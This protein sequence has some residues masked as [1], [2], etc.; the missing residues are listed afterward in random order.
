MR[1]FVKNL[2]QSEKIIAGVCWSMLLLFLNFGIAR[3][4]FTLLLSAYTLA[5]LLYVFIM[6]RV[7]GQDVS[8]FVLIS[9]LVRACVVFST[10]K[11]SDDIYRFL[12]DGNLFTHGINP[13]LYTPREV[14]A[15]QN[16]GDIFPIL[17]S[18]INSPDYFSVY[19][20]VLQFLFATVARIFPQSVTAQVF[21]FKF[22][23]F[24]FDCSVLTISYQ[25]SVISY[26]QINKKQSFYSEF[27]KVFK[28]SK[29][30]RDISTLN[31][32]LPTFN[33]QPSTQILWYALNPLVVTELCGNAHA[34]GIMIFFL[35]AA[36]YFFNRNEKYFFLSAL[37]MSLSIA[38]KLL[39]LMLLPFLMRYL[40]LKIFIKYIAV[41]FGLSAIYFLPFYSTVLVTHFRNSLGLYFSKFE[42]NASLFYVLRAWDFWW[43]GYDNIAQITPQLT[44]ATILFIT[45]LLRR[46]FKNA[47]STTWSSD[48]WEYILAALCF[49]FICATT[50]HPWYAVVP[51]AFAG[52]TQFR[53]P[54][55][56]T[57]T[58]VFTYSGYVQGSSRHTENYWW[59][60]AEYLSVVCFAFWELRTSKY[61]V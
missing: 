16:L 41:V 9:V 17:F 29:S 51:L 27:L 10:P 49:Y 31:L 47:V 39:P 20:P 35:L 22:F 57:F 28:S 56:W 6:Q 45:Y 36:I 53:F 5:F 13:F 48:F 43:K 44:A 11:L 55:L 24:L 58:I 37:C 60:A 3:H 61:K 52:F 1:N 34:E 18:R 4:Q 32:K 15:T 38:T 59:I 40:S 33:H 2:K 54:M 7:Q 14:L 30:L 25:L 50:V 19:P 46:Q 21:L 26:R 42:F 8:F 23:I 12:F